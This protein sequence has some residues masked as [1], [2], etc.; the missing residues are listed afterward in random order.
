MFLDILKYYFRTGCIEL[1]CLNDSKSFIMF[2][3]KSRD[4]TE[5]QWTEVDNIT[6]LNFSLIHVRESRIRNLNIN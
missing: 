5:E 6:K 3:L 4:E 2:N 1:K